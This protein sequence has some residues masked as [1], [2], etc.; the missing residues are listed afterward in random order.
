MFG[1]ISDEHRDEYEQ[2]LELRKGYRIMQLRDDSHSF[3]WDELCQWIDEADERMA[4]LEKMSRVFNFS[5]Q[6]D[7]LNQKWGI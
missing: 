6:I 4:E 2:L 3:S 5:A 1:K 7:N